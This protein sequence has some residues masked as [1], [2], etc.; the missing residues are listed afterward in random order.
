MLGLYDTDDNLWLGDDHGPF[1]FRR[2]PLAK[3][4]AMAVD[5][6]LR[7]AAGRT[8]AMTII[9]GGADTPRFTTTPEEALRLWEERR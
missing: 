8:R 3:I 7:Q 5:L 1:T 9:P 2:E 4:A 6:C